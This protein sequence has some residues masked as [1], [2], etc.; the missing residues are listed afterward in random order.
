MVVCPLLARCLIMLCPFL[1]NSQKAAKGKIRN[2]GMFQGRK[3]ATQISCYPVGVLQRMTSGRSLVVVRVYGL[4]W[5]AQAAP[6]ACQGTCTVSPH[7]TFLPHF[8]KS[9]KHAH[10][11]FVAQYHPNMLAQGSLNNLSS[12]SD[13]PGSHKILAQDLHTLCSPRLTCWGV[14]YLSEPAAGLLR[15]LAPC[16]QPLQ[17]V[18]CYCGHT[19][20]THSLTQQQDILFYGSWMA[21][22]KGGARAH[23]HSFQ[24]T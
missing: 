17:H 24:A 19:R 2:K 23:T 7:K 11:G 14:L 18:G 3:C 4:S 16:W 9:Q 15:E 10:T 20:S 21:C 12:L 13:I 22:T 5:P 1:D 8:L 6:T